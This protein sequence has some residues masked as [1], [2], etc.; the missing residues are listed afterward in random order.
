MELHLLLHIH[1]SKFIFIHLSQFCFKEIIP[2][3]SG[4]QVS[5]SGSHLSIR[6]NFIHATSSY[7]FTFVD[8]KIQ[9]IFLSKLFPRIHSYQLSYS[10]FIFWIAFI[11]VRE[12]HPWK[13]ISLFHILQ[14]ILISSSW[15]NISFT[16]RTR[17]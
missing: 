17:P 6:A 13:L 7:C 15:P 3:N 11:H 5:S 8:K 14:S 2:I 10:R 9:F 1:G 12:F 4:T 16:K